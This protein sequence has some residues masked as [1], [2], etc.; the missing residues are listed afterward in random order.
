[1]TM[2]IIM[3]PECGGQVSDKAKVCIHC[4]YP[5]IEETKVKKALNWKILAI[6]LGSL[7]LMLSLVFWISLFSKKEKSVEPKGPLAELYMQ[8]NNNQEEINDEYLQADNSEYVPS[9]WTPD[10]EIMAKAIGDCRFQYGA[11]SEQLIKL[12]PYCFNNYS[13]SYISAEEAVSKGNISRDAFNEEYNFD[14]AYVAFISGNLL[15]NIDLAAYSIYTE[16]AVI[17]IV[18]FDENGNTRH[19]KI[20]KSD[21]YFDAAAIQTMTR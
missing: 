15:P 17:V 19:S 4:G 13:I 1:M 9:V 14:Y 2:A 12:L 3:C 16:N 18:Y 10:K 21:S 11:L 20:Y 6:V 7:I 8:V 5:L